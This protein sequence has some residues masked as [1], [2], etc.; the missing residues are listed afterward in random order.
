[1]ENKVFNSSGLPIRR[2]IELLP[3]IFQTNANE[4]F[5]G[6]TL[7][8]LVQPGTLEKLS[9][10][11][12]RKYGKTFNSADTYI[13]RANTLRDAYQLEPAVVIRKNNR[14]S[15]YNDYI[16]FKNQLKFFGN[17]VERD[18]L[19][20]SS[21]SYAW[22][23]PIDWD[24]F[25]NYREYF[26]QPVGVDSVAVS[27]QARETVSSYRVRTNGSTEWIFFPDGLKKNPAITLYRGQTYEFDVNSPGDP[28]FIRTSNVLGEQSNYNK[29]VTNNGTQVGKVVFEVPNDAPDLLYYQSAN[30]RDR[31]GTFRIAEIKDNT[32]LD[33]E[34]DIIGKQKYVS[35]NSIRFTNG[36][37][38]KFEGQTSPAIY[39]Q[40][41]WVIEGVGE[42]IRLI[43]WEAIELPP[44]SNP[45]PEVLFDNGGF[46]DQPF[47]EALSYPRSKDYITIN[48]SSLDKNPWSRYNRWF[49]RSVLEYTA[50]INNTDARIDENLRAKRPIIEFNA[51]IQLHNHGAVAKTSI[52]LIDDFTSDVFSTIEGSSGYNIDGEPLTDGYRILFTADKDSLVRNKIFEVKFI[53]V[54]ASTNIINRRQISLV[55]TSDSVSDAGECLVVK[56]G[57][58]NRNRMFHFDGETWIRSQEKLTVNQPPRFDVFDN[59]EVSFGDSLKY[60]TSSFDGSEIISYVVGTGKNDNELGFPLSYLNINN[61]GDIQFEFDWD[62]DQFSYQENF[63]IISESVNK[64]YYRINKTLTDYEYKNSWT[65]VDSKYLQ[66]IIQ[67]VEISKETNIVFSTAC[68][69]NSSTRDKTI[70]YVNGNLVEPLL[71]EIENN[72]K[73][74]TFK[75]IL[76]VGDSVTFKVYTDAEPVSGYYEIPFGLERNPLNQ[77]LE[78]FTLGQ[79]NDHLGSMVEL[80]DNFVGSYP[81]SS[82]L[83]DLINYEQ[84]GRRFLKHAGIPSLSINLLCNKETNI[85]NSIKFASSEYE[86]FKNNFLTLAIELPYDNNDSIKFVDDI[87]TTIAQAKTVKSPFVDSDMIGSGAFSSINYIVEDTGI[88]TFALGDKFDLS[89]ISSKAVYVYINN[90]QGINGKDYEF[91]STFG[92]VKIIK[93]LN[94][95]DRIQIK[96]YFSTSFNFIPPTPTK[97]G[98]YKKYEPE[99]FIDDTYLEPKKVIR[100][101]DGSITVAFN[102]F[103][104]ELLLEL[105]KRIF[106]NIKIEYSNQIFDIDNT[107]SSFYNTGIFKISEFNSVINQEFLRW[108]SS[109]DIDLYRNS[110]YQLTNPFSYTYA[111]V[112]DRPTKQPLPGFWRGI[113]LALYDTDRPHTS[114][115]E[116]LGFSQKPLWWDTEYGPAPYTSGNLLLWEDLRDGVIRQ[117]DRSGQYARYSRPNLLDIIPTDEEG[118]LKNPLLLNVLS[119]Y[120]TF[121]NELDFKFGDVA[122]VEYAWRKSS[123]YP[124]TVLFA[125]SLLRPFEF[126]SA[127]L[128]KNKVKKNKLGQLVNTDTNYFIKVSDLISNLK[129]DITPS[130][131]FY[132]IDNFL[133][134][135]LKDK[136]QLI[137]KLENYDINIGNRI[138]GFVDKSQQRYI[139]DSKNPQASTSSVFIPPEDYDIFFNVGSSIQSLTYS[140]VIVEKSLRGWIISGYDKLNTYFEYYPILPTNADPKIFVGGV[141]ETY[142]TWQ[143]RQFYTKG[144]IVR[145]N[146]QFYRAIIAHTSEEKFDTTKWVKITQIPL[147]GAIEASKRS[148][149]DKTDLRKF[150]YGT[151]LENIQD[152]VDFLLGYGE[153]LKDLGFVFDEFSN[154]L[155]A[156]ANW[157][158]TIKEFMFWTSHNWAPGAILSLSPSAI[159]LKIVSAGGVADNLLDSFYEYSILKSDGTKLLSS[160]IDVT[161]KYNEFAL[162]PVD[163]RDGIYFARI[164]YVLK[165]HVVVFSDRTMF[166]DVIFDKGPGYRQQRIKVLGFRTTDWDGDYTSPGFLFDDVNIQPWTP[167][168][169][170]K[171][172]DIV[173]YKEFNYVSKKAQSGQS[174]F[175]SSRWEKLDSRP[176]TGLVANF[177]YRIN[178]FEDFYDLDSDGLGSSQRDL[179]RHSIGY[180]S[181][182]YLRDLAED[183][184]TQYRLYQGFIREKG[185]NNSIKK[186]F[187][188]ISS[189]E[190]DAIEI[191]EE[192]AFRLGQVGGTDQFDEIEFKIGKDQ[193]K[194][195]PQPIIL[196]DRTIDQNFYKNYIVLSEQNY[197]IGDI[198]NTVIKT[199]NIP[200]PEW[201]AGYVNVDDV[202]FVVKNLDEL[203][204]NDVT[205]FNN[206]SVLWVTYMPGG[207]DILR[208]RIT[209]ITVIAV[210]AIDQ[211]NAVITTNRP[212]RLTIG[213]IIGLTNIRGLSG[214]YKIKATNS[215][216]IIVEVAGFEEAPEIDQSSFCNIGIFLPARISNAVELIEEN[217]SILPVGSKVWLDKNA[218]G[219]WEVLQ[220]TKQYNKTGISEYGVSFPAGMGSA[221]AYVPLRDQTIISNPGARVATNDTARDS[222][223]VVYTQSLDG[224]I[225]SQILNPIAEIAPEL[226]GS[227][228]TVLTVSPDGRWLLVASPTAS[229]IPSGFKGQFSPSA[230]YNT[231]DTVIFTGKL[232]KANKPILGDGSTINL[233]N[234]DWSPV[235]LHE[236]QPAAKNLIGTNPGY[237]KQGCV[238]IF[239]YTQGQWTYRKTII[240][241]R[242]DANELFGSSISIGKEEGIEGTSGDVTLI[243]KAIDTAGGITIVDAVGTSGLKD[244]IYQ[245]IGGTDISDS[246]TGASFNITKS[247]GTYVATVRNGGTRYALGD[248]IKIL[249][250]QLGGTSPANDLLITVTAIDTGGAIV[251]SATYSNL[252]GI[253]SIIPANQAVFNVTRTRST[254]SVAVINRGVGY[255]GRSIVSYVSPGLGL[256]YYGCIKDTQT[257]RG[258]WDSN[259]IYYPGDVVK[260]PFRSSSYYRVKDSVPEVQFVLPTDTDF[261]EVSDPIIPT[262]REY[263]EEVSAGTFSL[264]ATP[265]KAFVTTTSEGNLGDLI[266]YTAGSTI[267]IPGT[268]LGGDAPANNLL[269]RVS[270][271]LPVTAVGT[272]ENNSTV[273]VGSTS[274]LRAD[275]PI[276]F[277]GSTVGGI[278]A[279]TQYFVKQ[280]INNSSFTIYSD[281]TTKQLISLTSASSPSANPMRF[282]DNSIRSFTI[283]GTA[284][285]GISF[286]GISVGID[287][288][289]DIVGTDI[290]QSGSGA[291]F[292]LVRANGRY[293][294]T[295]NVRGTR[296]NVG[297]Q[298]RILGSA[299]G[300][301]PE[302]YYMSISAPGAL[303]NKGRIYL[304]TFDGIDWKQSDDKN[305]VGIFDPTQD[306]SS[307]SIVWHN[308]NYWK[309][310]TPYFK[311]SGTTITES[312]PGWEVVE[313]LNTGILP[314]QPAHPNDG[315]S[316]EFGLIDGQTPELLNIGDQYGFSTS[317]SADA[318]ILV[319]GAP[320]ADT[321]DLENY[322]GV[323]KSFQEYAKDDV[324]KIV[325]LNAPVY[326]KLL[327]NSSINQLPVQGEIWQKVVSASEFDTGSVFVYLKNQNNVYELVQTID[328]DDIDTD[329]L[330]SGDELGF[331]VVLNK[332]GNLLFVSAPDADIKQKDKGAV[333]VFENINNRFEYIQR[334]ESYSFDSFERFGDQ[335]SVSP[336]SNTVAITAGSAVS[337][338]LINFDR[339]ATNFD[340]LLT[341]FRDPVGT[342]GK[343][344]IYNRYGNKFILSESFDEGLTNGESFGRALACFDDRIIIGS[345]TFRSSEDAFLG[346]V[347][348]KAQTF[349]KSKNVNAWTPIQSQEPVVDLS[350]L[351][352]LSLFD[353]D[354]NVKLLDVD[355]IDPI[356]GKILSVAEQELK[357]KTSY[358]PAVYSVG[359][360][361][362]ESRAWFES[363]VGYLWW[364]TGTV[365]W[366][367]YNQ[368]DISYRIGRW[369]TPVFGSSV[370]IYE[371]VE[372]EY[373]P[374]EWANISITAEAFSLGV[375]GI[376]LY[377]ND[378]AYSVK[379]NVDPLT[380]R[381]SSK[382]YY[383]W[384][385]NKSTLPINKNF[386]KITASSVAQYIENPI[387][388]G[389]TFAALIDNDK[390]A[391]YNP[392]LA[393]TG[394]NV[395]VTIQFYKNNKNINQIHREYQLLT[396]GVAD[397][398]PTSELENKWID[399]LIGYD[400][401]GREV[402]DFK[403][404]TKFKYGVSSRPRQSIFV[405]RNKAV[406]ITLDFINNILKTRSFAEV[407]NTDRLNSFD[408]APADV[409]NLYDKTVETQNE[410][411]LISTSKISPAVLKANI[412]NGRIDTVDVISTGYGYK[413]SPPIVITGSGSG[414]ALQANIDKL[415]RV[416]SVTVINPGSKYL[417]A[418]LS[419]RQ[420]AVLVKTDPT[421]KNYWSIYS[422]NE[423]SKEFYRTATQSFDTRN[424]WNTIDWWEAGFSEKSRIKEEIV[425]LYEES[426]IS[427][428]VGQLLRIREYGAGGWAVLERTTKENSTIFDRYRLVGR[429]NGTIQ[430]SDRFINTEK[431]STGY[432]KT[433]SFDSAGYDESSAREFRIILEAIKNDIFIDDLRVEWNKLFFANIHYAFSE[434]LYIDWAFKTSFVNAIHNVG[435]LTQKITYKSDNLPSYQKYIEE[436][437]PYRT[438]IRE[439]TSRY[440]NVENTLTSVSDFDLPAVYNSDTNKFE[441]IRISSSEIDTYP[442][443]YWLDNYKYSV[444]DIQIS[445]FGSGYRTVPIVV[446]EGGGG[447]GASARAFISNGRVSRVVLTNG[448]SGYTSAPVV[449]LVG[450]V[451]TNL[452]NAA[453]A[454]AF[455]G[456]SKARVFDLSLKFDRVSKTATFASTSLDE[457]FKET[458]IF[459]GTGSKT[460]FDLK[461]PS[462]I[463]KTKVKVYVRLNS[464]PPNSLG[465]KLLTGQYSLSIDNIKVDG[466]TVEVGK[467]TINSAPAKDSVITVEYEKND[468]VL[469]SLNRIDKY[470]NPTAGMTGLEKTI[471]R[472]D[473]T[474][475]IIKIEHDYSQLITG[476]DFGGV[477]VQGA[478]LDV[479]GGWDALPWF[480]EGWDSVDSLNSDFY[481]TADGTSNIFVLPEAPIQG[482]LI[483]VYL[484]NRVTGMYERIDDPDF[485]T[486]N[487][488]LP[489][490]VMDT[491]IGDGS[492]SSVVIPSTVSIQDGDILIFRPDT[493][494]GSLSITDLN[495]IDADVSGGTLSSNTIGTLVAPNAINGAYATATGLTAAEIIIEGDKF[496]SPDQVPAPEENIP[497]QVLEAISIKVFHSDRTGAPSVLSR[498]YTADGATN[499]FEIG[500]TILEN[501]S[502]IVFI[503]KVKQVVDIDYTF[504]SATQQVRFLTAPSADSLI[505]LFSIS[506][507]GVEILDYREFVGDGSNRYFLT[508]ASYAETGR[509]FATVNYVST[510]VAF[511]NSNGVVNN[512]DKSL[513]EFGIA[514]A[515]GSNVSIIVLSGELGSNESIVRANYQTITISNVAQKTY[516]VTNF[517]EL[518]ASATG[519]IIVELNNRLLRCA[520]T[521]VQV[522]D[523]TN[524]IVNVGRD[525]LKPFGGIVQS[526]VRA[527]I[528]NIPLIFGI[529]YEFSAATNSVNI[530]KQN[531]NRNDIIRVETYDN[532]EFEII[533]NNLVLANDLILAVG[534]KINIIWF[535]RYSSIDLVKDLRTGGQ[536]NYPLQRPPLGVSYVW[537]YKNGVR[538]T[539]DVEFYIDSPRNTVYLKDS[540]TEDDE[541]EIISFASDVY[542]QP[543]AYEIFKDVLN[544]HHFTRYSVTDVKLTKNLNYFDDEITVNDA[545]ALTSPKLKLPGIVTINGERIEYLLKDGNVLRNLRRGTLGTSIAVLHPTNSDVVDV[546]YQEVVPYK[547]DQSRYDF[548]ADGSSE[549]YTGLPFVPMARKNQ[550]GIIVPFTYTSTIP[551]GFYPCDTIEVFVQGR[552][553]RKD[554]IVVYDSA[555]GSHSPIGDVTIEAEFSVDNQTNSIR[556]THAPSAGARITV[557]KRSGNV[558]YNQGLNDVT[559]GVTLSQNTTSIAKFL[560]QRTT[561]LL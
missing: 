515:Q 85:I 198:R 509:V 90:E 89:V 188:K 264:L 263:W 181:R 488:V 145:Y 187:D 425:G 10:Y 313:V 546:G 162:T 44:I 441:P 291:I 503:D 329:D 326:Y 140:G 199:K 407:I 294:A 385:K 210:A 367:N 477:V 267:L 482:Q 391:L 139:L 1:M 36:L 325:E 403:L 94:E 14:I 359:A 42:S 353:S 307:G 97:M 105:E 194:L 420:F 246:G 452:S 99:I 504:E 214:F 491:F 438:K 204:G 4:K 501:A 12:G 372:S 375:T 235:D 13:D 308:N 130:G 177:D 311:N 232:W 430:L 137:E 408:E 459:T 9:G 81:G 471:V 265:W 119:N 451:G 159:K 103:R 423:K 87:L 274:T 146:E 516:N 465:Q 279:G 253:N 531:I 474:Q 305:F 552:R 64:G 467:L 192:W 49:H 238:D 434:Q 310:L 184:V 156:V 461:Y 5:L 541:I 428:E 328:D 486:G 382:L 155:Q 131:L 91:D 544:G 449:K 153:R 259:S 394:N 107:I 377:A 53:T 560:Q 295:V 442:W 314:I 66:A 549:I 296:Y 493:S 436:V 462:A 384:V 348:G 166:N 301:V 40:G 469:D 343:V 25:V 489:T 80:I 38:I 211:R 248:Q 15:E 518:Q 171:L 332:E 327:A 45:N 512:I 379:E 445:N 444:V 447:T 33:V 510:P 168:V 448:G 414:A 331:N 514:P 368:G 405:D 261:W 148:Y 543:F 88:N 100:G 538:L 435:N 490:A 158:T 369:N 222:A 458:E 207:W 30:T 46:D 376:P 41:T 86:K 393:I 21:D 517:V 237:P 43:N 352:S 175:D 416:V 334:L 161:R 189:V 457:K 218:D 286:S 71:T 415:G 39:K 347:I 556:I 532:I 169:D 290:S 287:S 34:K 223:V 410:L 324:V 196:N 365:K 201:G 143:E 398:I 230:G 374:S 227:Y 164:N 513:V 116:M 542:K 112:S 411:R 205:Q 203:I 23:P 122:P 262:N 120:S 127:N 276:V 165:E 113:F 115:W 506:I 3:D 337:S 231:N 77:N 48:R 350:L 170:Y 316:I 383:F 386:R 497:G 529:E 299:I 83:R 176:E 558:W 74:V 22:S 492:T 215:T 400:I 221:V 380:G 206:G 73:K 283:S 183:E 427:L 191:N 345:P 464:D 322:K 528:N 67:Q 422:W 8:A 297:D 108:S 226:L 35:A 110:F 440:I 242:P 338:T 59:D 521:V 511:V 92:F 364:D 479:S 102:D 561:K 344:Y 240:S 339:G 195:N 554:P 333:F 392:T 340:Y 289:S 167:F 135:D 134:V 417:S 404:P 336:T 197:Q 160:N 16:D 389:I 548:V 320:F 475:E 370:D 150:S 6:A 190:N 136:T 429:A 174:E 182:D 426:E 399:S 32:F 505:E 224:L 93:S 151:P 234:E 520:D 373:L 534:D 101:H 128:D 229:A 208:Y 47:D 443:K 106:N 484:R 460:V 523:G 216:T 54:Q 278:S 424:Y 272:F 476:I 27:G 185:T 381:I 2:T 450:G 525:P 257:D 109:T 537:V 468:S 396:E 535:D 104:D 508:A 507:G 212:H 233:S 51:D 494:D 302:A 268:S 413:V 409:K 17:A 539:P 60:N 293:T 397:S 11:I 111:R 57:A 132:Y 241:P 147:V 553:L 243:V 178:Q 473:I 129:T 28:F 70:C 117:G 121:N 225:P 142:I 342:T 306:Y 247:G 317:M 455:I 266:K 280:I 540:N 213:T 18:D 256:R 26:W 58:E 251:G 557:I 547:E 277:S 527:Y 555:E 341:K 487:S 421:V 138:G 149:F 37:R 270:P 50:E 124:F 31:V 152:V 472:D 7:D 362:D 498:I 275:M 252:T 418:S 95:G 432:D 76:N 300:G 186:I 62:S 533:D 318:S 559:S 298:I 470:Y 536:L 69:W 387:G 349:R 454:V 55:E 180:Q 431:N 24:K 141:S 163:I 126:I 378:S 255:T 133:K 84:Y 281:P 550:K 179:A 282:V 366:S 433:S 304:Y 303:N 245:N 172:G 321:A 173:T 499:L 500:Q 250:T 412:A 419:V 390:L 485:S 551:D 52:D 79:L 466:L 456:N 63:Q 125:L 123:S 363:M 437:K 478:T 483:T 288:Y 502:V 284:K 244:A 96:E 56:R 78:K 481:I 358:D 200:T 202:D 217:F 309:A 463:D 524:R 355:V 144:I 75:D 330:E 219:K 228:G 530:I 495:L 65:L 496:I 29:G 72:I 354:L 446:F 545:S 319:V 68:D 292:D 526:Q 388:T 453:T 480:T 406:R 346:A 154:E 395:S 439:Y 269:I 360:S 157:E 254:Y 193:F 285:A 114:P 522:F 98:M 260:Y 351:K 220:R 19:I 361:A 356:N 357:F 209:D 239:E 82:N 258:V 519:N 401:T 249:G 315:S 61:S 118:D 335:I 312:T 273:I 371:W 323:W 271:N 236:A 20:T 402:P